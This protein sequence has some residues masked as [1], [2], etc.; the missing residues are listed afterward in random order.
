[1]EKRDNYTRC[2][3][4]GMLFKDTDCILDEIKGLRCPNGCE[5]SFEQAPYEP[6]TNQ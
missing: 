6:P 4:C 5:E 1:M 2:K 3:Q